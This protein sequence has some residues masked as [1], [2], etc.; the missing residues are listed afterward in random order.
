MEERHLLDTDRILENSARKLRELE[1]LRRNLE[2]EEDSLEKEYL[3]LTSGKVL[4]LPEELEKELDDL[5][6]HTVYGMEWLKKNGYSQKKNQMLVRKNPFL[7]YALILTRQEIE[8]LGR[9]DRNVCTSF[10]VPIV[11]R[12]KIEEFQ[13]KYTDKI[14]NFPGISFYILFNENLLDEEKLQAMIWEKKKELEKLNQAVDQRKKEY[15]EYFSV[16]KH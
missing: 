4:E 9:N 1:E 10:P 12:E 6:I 3:S 8:K 7:P 14:V 5:G 11:E 13:E 2:K 15:A 16:R